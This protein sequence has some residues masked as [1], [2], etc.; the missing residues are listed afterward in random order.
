MPV[1]IK[2]ELGNIP[3]VHAMFY[4]DNKKPELKLGEG[5][6]A[7][8]LRY[9]T[10]KEKQELRSSMAVVAQ[11]ITLAAIRQNAK[12]TEFLQ[13]VV[14]ELQTELAKR[15]GDKEITFDQVSSA[16][17][18]ISDYFDN[19]RNGGR[20]SAEQVGKFFDEA[21]SNWL[22][23]RVVAKFPQFDAD[24]VAKVVLQYRQAFCDLAKIGLPHSKQVAEMLNKAWNEFSWNSDDEEMGQWISAKLKKLM[25][26]HNAAEMLIDAI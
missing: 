9:K 4:S 15:C 6:I 3:A 5:E 25:D 23:D 22:M 12:G 11:Q 8:Y 1:T 21:L 10:D 20:V 7:H 19:S 17:F 24:K 2:Q 16:D 18:L 14:D 26:R 13:S